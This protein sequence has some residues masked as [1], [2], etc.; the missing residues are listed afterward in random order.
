M[1][2]KK[3]AGAERKALIIEAGAKLV[4]KHGAPNV[5]RRMVAQAAKV[6][7]ALVSAHMGTSEDAQKVYARKA[8][9]LKLSIPDKATT[10][11]N[12]KK[13]RAHK[14]RDK[15]D[16]RKRSVREVKAIANKRETKPTAPRERKPATPTS[17]R[18]TTPGRS[19]KVPETKSAAR[20]PKAPP[21]LP[22]VPAS[23]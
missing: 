14:P 7:E 16:T 5:T 23:A 6:S 9:A 21:V 12:G 20:A 19:N 3:I 8:K 22:Q 4:S 10:E 15:R 18:V 1:S 13:L 2:K 17:K 11:A